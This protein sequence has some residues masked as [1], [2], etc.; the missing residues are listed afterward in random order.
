[1]NEVIFNFICSVAWAKASGQY[2]FYIHYGITEEWHAVTEFTYV[3][4]ITPERN[5]F[6]SEIV[7]NS[8]KSIPGYKQKGM[9]VVG[10][11]YG[12]IYARLYCIRAQRDDGKI[13]LLIGKQKFRSYFI[14]FV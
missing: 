13:S 7:H 4:E 5:E 12:A 3:F 1:M 10:D 8:F 6:V 2:V 14:G 9:I 11:D